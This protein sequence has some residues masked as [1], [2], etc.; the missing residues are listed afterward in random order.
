[1]TKFN[2]FHV[3]TS[4]EVKSVH[5]SNDLIA[6]IIANTEGRMSVQVE[7]NNFIV[8]PKDDRKRYTVI[9]IIDSLKS[10]MKFSMKLTYDRFKLRRQ[11][12]FVLLNMSSSTLVE[13]FEILW[14]K[15]VVNANAIVIDKGEV[16]MLSFIPFQHDKC[17]DFTPVVIN[18]F[19]NRRW[20]N[21]N[22]YPKKFSNLFNCSLRFGA[23][24]IFPAVITRNK[25]VK[26]LH[27][28]EVNL[29]RIFAEAK[30]FSID[31][32]LVTDRGAVFENQTATGLMKMLMDGKVNGIIGLYSFQLTA[33][34]LL[35]ETS[36]Y[37]SV[38][39]VLVVPTGKAFSAFFKLVQ[40]F[41]I[42][43][44]ISI[45]IMFVGSFVVKVLYKNYFFTNTDE[46][47]GNPYMNIIMAITGQSQKK[48]PKENFSRWILTM[49]LIFW[50]IT[51]TMYAGQLFKFLQTSQNERG[52]ETIGEMVQSNF[53]FYISEN[54]FQRMIFSDR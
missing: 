37:M 50:F 34:M 17:S 46:F 10:F 49:C 53:T 36:S 18:E 27:G 5:A 44:W 47:I 11:F 4:V 54:I 51:R 15:F 24:V 1:M 22:F 41:D 52:F 43:A 28:L 12:L 33:S 9:V 35:G 40:P 21:K 42:A 7:E 39:I 29:L 6:E 38:P 14:Q 32:E 3:I 8:V 45:S 16:R 2:N 13:V 30:N 19:S 25:D 48:L 31:F 26:N 23:T 20:V